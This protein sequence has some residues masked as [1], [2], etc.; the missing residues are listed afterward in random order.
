VKNKVLPTTVDGLKEVILQKDVQIGHLERENVALKDLIVLLRRKKF[1]PQSEQVSQE[2]LGL[3]NEMEQESIVEELP[4]DQ[5]ENSQEEM[6][7]AKDTPKKD[8]RPRI[9]EGLPRETVVID[10]K[11]HEKF[12]PHDGSPLQ[13]MEPEISE[14]LKI[15]PAKVTVI[16]TIRKKYA[17]PCC[18]EGMKTAP[19][20]TSL[21]PKTM[22]S[23][24]LIAYILIA[25]FMDHLPLYRQ[26][27]IFARVGLLLSRQTMARWL[28][29]VYLKLMPLYNL[30]QERMLERD[31]MQMDETRTL[32]LNEEGKKATSKS[33]MWVRHTPGKNPIILYD[34]A[35][36]R[37]GSVPLELLQGFK[38]YLQVDGYDGYANACVTY[39]LMRLGCNDHCRRKF[40]DA[41]KTSN[42][43]GVG[44]KGLIYYKKLYEIEEKIKDKTPEERYAARQKESKKILDEMKLWIDDIR[45]KTTPNS[46]AGKAINYAYNE[47][48]YLIRYLDDG[49]LEISNILIENKIRP[50]ALGRKNWLFS[51]SV[52]GAQASAMYYSLIETAKANGL[53]P[54][55]YLSKVLE[56]L[57]HAKTLED[58]ERLLPFKGQ[59]LA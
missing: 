27:G 24:S 5:N 38:G 30:L 44:K 11:D 57:P 8:R 15:I 51:S 53:E 52:E 22:A 28:I 12:C 9:P 55:D 25:K 37:S 54:F 4:E 34:Y 41:F 59:F 2:Q 14:K 40:H 3:F 39:Q 36:T 21:L 47:W 32:V 49:K 10:L 19:V 45:K 17:C 50:F 16:Q 56:N 48:Q 7:G 35:P 26:E 23:A 29:E 18:D 33:Y 43:K 6:K 46:I 42:G 31:Y 1:A 13:E 20:P 58:F